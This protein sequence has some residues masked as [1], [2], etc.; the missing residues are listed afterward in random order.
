MCGIYGYVGRELAY[1]IILNGLKKLEYRGHDSWGIV[2]LDDEFYK[3]KKIGCIDES[4]SESELLGNVGIGHVRWATRGAI[5]ETNAHP[6]FDCKN[7]T[8]IVHNG[9]IFNAAHLKSGLNKH[10]LKS[11]TDTELFV[12]LLEEKLE[13]NNVNKNFIKNIHDTLSF[14]EGYYAFLMLSK[15]TKKLYAIRNKSPIRIG[16]G[17]G[18]YYVSSD[19]VS[20]V[21]KVNEFMNLEDGDIAEISVDGVRIYDSDMNLVERKLNPVNILPEIIDKGRYPYF[22]LKEIKEIDS[23]VNNIIVKYVTANAVNFGID[24]NI[25]KGAGKIILSGAGSSYFASMIGEYYLRQFLENVNV[26]SVLSSELELKYV[27][28]NFPQKTVL[29]ALTQSGETKDTNDAIEFA[30]Q[31]GIAVVSL[32]NKRHSETEK[33]SDSV[34]KLL[35]REE[36]SVVATKTFVAEVL[37]LLLLSIA[38]SQDKKKYEILDAIKK[39]PDTL[40]LIEENEII[41][42]AEK[43]YRENEIYPLSRGILAPV[44]LEAGRKIEE[45]LYAHSIGTS[46]GSSAELKHGPLTMVRDKVMLFLVPPAAHHKII[47]NIDEVKARDAKIIVV[48]A[49]GDDIIG[50]L[51]KESYIDDVIWIPKAHELVSPILYMVPLYLL[52][53]YMA[54]KKKKAGME[55][56]NPD[57]PRYLAKSITVD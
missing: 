43:Y 11:D 28:T 40:R 41:R 34:I 47:T 8:A 5:S 25:F 33:I 36:I 19:I 1:P 2:T 27:N 35:A 48:A 52:V 46:M 51:E 17:N 49:Q 30:K 6:H 55:Q 32:V 9:V 24:M 21:G 14:I 44:A 23:V 29:I 26:E 13:E 12:H 50:N 3:I 42:I 38:L 37:V 53:Y 31:K 4:A 56:I 18:G 54:V 10:L 39:L 57:R 16:I 7:E 20:F 22:Y 45:I 15:S